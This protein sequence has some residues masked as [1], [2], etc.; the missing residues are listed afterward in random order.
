ME[1]GLKR[2]EIR[3]YTFRLPDKRRS[4]LILTR[5]PL[6]SILGRVS[7]AP[8]TT[9]IRG[10]P[11]EVVL[12]ISDGMPVRSAINFDNIH[13]V[14][15]DRL[16]DPIAILPEERWDEVREAILHA[17]GFQSQPSPHP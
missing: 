16:G 10:V 8:V 3:W 5:D 14:E 13:T 6:A 9:A 7:V 17:F 4:V 11:T 15:S 2:G 1:S 12:D